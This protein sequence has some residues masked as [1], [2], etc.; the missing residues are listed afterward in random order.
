MRCPNPDCREVFVVREAAAKPAPARPGRPK[1]VVWSD[2]AGP[3]APPAAAAPAPAAE[4]DDE[5]FRRRRGR[6]AI[7]AGIF[8]GIVVAIF[9]VGGAVVGRL[10]WNEIQ[11]ES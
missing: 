5:P 10:I 6:R 9:L 11:T 4:D 3:P 1:E 2:D 7:P 8:V